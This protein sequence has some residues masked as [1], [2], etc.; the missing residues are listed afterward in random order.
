MHA[1]NFSISSRS[2]FRR[3]V[4]SAS[5]FRIL[6]I[7]S[8]KSSLSILLPGRVGAHPKIRI[9]PH[10]AL[11]IPAM[12]LE[13]SKL[14]DAEPCELHQNF[15]A[16]QRSD[17]SIRQK[18]GQKDMGGNHSILLPIRG[19]LFKDRAFSLWLFNQIWKERHILGN[20]FVRLPPSGKYEPAGGRS[21]QFFRRE[22]PPCHFASFKWIKPYLDGGHLNFQSR[23]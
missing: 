18:A 3:K 9:G 12:P 10:I 2:N 21:G 14:S 19:S 20:G 17:S 5:V 22:G 8:I 23:I 1:N 11:V 4:R 7:R 16:G 13:Q 6:L 15:P